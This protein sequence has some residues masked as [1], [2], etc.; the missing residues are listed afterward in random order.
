MSKKEK[1]IELLIFSLILL[2]Y[3]GVAVGLVLLKIYLVPSISAPIIR[4]VTHFFLGI[5]FIGNLGG[6]FLNIYF[7]YCALTEKPIQ[8]TGDE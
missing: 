1:C 7:L 2:W 8:I 3:I 5:L 6:V 4:G